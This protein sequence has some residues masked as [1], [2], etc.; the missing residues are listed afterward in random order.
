MLCIKQEMKC[1]YSELVQ[2]VAYV[3]VFIIK[4]YFFCTHLHENITGYYRIIEL[5]S[6]EL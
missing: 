5:Y 6:L 3:M 1:K 2:Y 4:I